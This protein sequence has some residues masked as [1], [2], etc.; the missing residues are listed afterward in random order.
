[1][2]HQETSQGRKISVTEL[3]V[4][5]SVI[6]REGLSSQEGVKRLDIYGPYE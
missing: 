2:D 5:L 3:I 6:D 4:E 1:M